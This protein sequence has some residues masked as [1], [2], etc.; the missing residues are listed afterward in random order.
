MLEE[1]CEPDDPEVRSR[2]VEQP[3]E[4]LGVRLL[5]GEDDE[6]RLLRL[7]DRTELR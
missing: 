6:I 5:V 2:H 3:V 4:R 7:D 1:A